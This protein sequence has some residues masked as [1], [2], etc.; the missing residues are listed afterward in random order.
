MFIP[1]GAAEAELM[2]VAPNATLNPLAWIS[3]LN[4]Y[5]YQSAG[6]PQIILG[7]MGAITEAASKDSISC[8]SANNRRRTA[9][10]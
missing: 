4:D 6:V 2:A 3:S 1:S 8:I 5:F 10:H 7:G 9:I